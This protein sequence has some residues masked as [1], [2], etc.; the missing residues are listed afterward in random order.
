MSDL[1]VLVNSRPDYTRARPGI[2]LITLINLIQPE[3][4]VRAPGAS[5][6]SVN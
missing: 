2:T 6:I 3:A 1:A 5:N 4:R